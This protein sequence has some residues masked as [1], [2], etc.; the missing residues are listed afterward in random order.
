MLTRLSCAFLTTA[1]LVAADHGTSVLWSKP[2]DLPIDTKE[3]FDPRFGTPAFNDSFWVGPVIC[4]GNV[5]T[6]KRLTRREAASL[7]VLELPCRGEK[8]AD[9]TPLLVDVL[10]RFFEAVYS[11][12][13]STDAVATE[14][15]SVEKGVEE[16]TI[17]VAPAIA[18]VGFAGIAPAA[19]ACNNLETMAGQRRVQVMAAARLYTIGAR[20][21]KAGDWAMARN[22]FE[23]VTRVCPNCDYAVMAKAQ[24]LRI[25]SRELPE[26]PTEGGTEEQKDPPKVEGQ[27]D[28][29][30]E[31]RAS[32]R[33]IH[34]ARRMFARGERYEAAGKFDKAY[35]CYEEARAVCPACQFG[36]QA[37]ERMVVLE[38][39]RYRSVRG[40]YRLTTDRNRRVDL[41]VAGRFGAEEQSA[42]P[43]RFRRHIAGSLRRH[44]TLRGFYLLGERHRRLAAASIFGVP[45]QQETP[46]RHRRHRLTEIEMQHRMEARALYLLGERCRRGGD[47]RMAATFYEECFGV[48]PWSYYTA[49]ANERLRQVETRLRQQSRLEGAET[50]ELREGA[51][52]G[53]QARRWAAYFRDLFDNLKLQ[54]D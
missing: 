32:L 3:T 31:N 29:I 46:V 47:L 52:S 50:Q 22:C 14:T 13:S 25:S 8:A 24:L 9:A 19:A 12:L 27:R 48:S 20:C 18:M 44:Y 42:P 21:A 26:L 10:T 53:M 16:Q 35:D 41:I 6:E 34:E 51:A 49:R 36:Q 38:T 43:L 40:H 7:R 2:P 1:L 28:L 30:L 15:Q 17:P 37:R 33:R 54:W 39:R 23:E 45:Q 4:P 11:G 5:Q